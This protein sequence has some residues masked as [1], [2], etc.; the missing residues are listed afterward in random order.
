VLGIWIITVGQS[1]GFLADVLY[2]I[3]ARFTRFDASM[4][5]FFLAL[6]V[7]TALFI[8]LRQRALKVSAVILVGIVGGAIAANSIWADLGLARLV[9][10]SLV[11]FLF[12]T[13]PFALRAMT[14]RPP[15]PADRGVLPPLP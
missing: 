14:A 6:G 1:A 4:A 3:E 11:L 2:S 5:D 8:R 12:L 7:S 10:L 13:S 9:L 15:E